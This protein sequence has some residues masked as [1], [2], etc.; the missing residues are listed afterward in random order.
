MA[1][2]MATAPVAAGVDPTARPETLEVSAF[3]RMVEQR[4]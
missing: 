1:V 2:A 3:Q 4:R